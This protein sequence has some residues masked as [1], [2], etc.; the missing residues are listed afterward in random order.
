MSAV[1]FDLNGSLLDQK[2]YNKNNHELYY[3]NKIMNLYGQIN[4][5]DLSLGIDKF[6]MI[7]K[8][9]VIYISMFDLCSRGH[10]MECYAIDEG[11]WLG[12]SY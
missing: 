11:S 8:I 6:D 7:F 10:V 2:E 4:K 12:A 1:L 9:K 3:C 5:S